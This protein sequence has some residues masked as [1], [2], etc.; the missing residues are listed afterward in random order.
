M[1]VVRARSP[2]PTL[3]CTHGFSDANE[4]TN[5]GGL[6]LRH[7]I[8]ATQFNYHFADAGIDG[9]LLLTRPRAASCKSS[10]RDGHPYLDMI[11]LRL[12]SD[13]QARALPA[14]YACVVGTCTQRRWSGE[15]LTAP[16]TYQPLR[17]SRTRREVHTEV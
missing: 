17:S 2:G 3:G 1:V 6:Y 9:D 7:D 13:G 10:P 15:S 12:V 16:A 8:D 14:A 4:F 11:D 5:R